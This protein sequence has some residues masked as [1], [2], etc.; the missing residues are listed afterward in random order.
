[1]NLLFHCKSLNVSV[2]KSFPLGPVNISKEK[3]L[4]LLLGGISPAAFVL[5]PLD[6]RVLT[7]SLVRMQ[8]S[9]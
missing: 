3:S 7:V 6:G 9:S 8:T 5:G 4:I 1:M 2:S